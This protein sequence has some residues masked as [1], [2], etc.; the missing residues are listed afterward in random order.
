M[1][2]K[3]TEGGKQMT[4]QVWM[5]ALLNVQ[6]KSLIQFAHGQYWF[7]IN[8]QQHMKT[9]STFRACAMIIMFTH[10]IWRG[11]WYYKFLI[12][13]AIS[14][15]LDGVCAGFNYEQNLCTFKNNL[16]GRRR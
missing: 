8:L 1:S 14:N 5:V 11:I 12:Y 3:W 4:F 16:N 7:L 2:C 10:A 15:Y 13:V 6:A 9:D